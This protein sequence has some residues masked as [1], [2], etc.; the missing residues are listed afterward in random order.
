MRGLS[1]LTKQIARYFFSKMGFLGGT[2][3]NCNKRPN[4][5]EL[6][7]KSREIKERNALLWTWETLL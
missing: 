4:S 1:T 2:T 3:K 6:G 5:G 7:M